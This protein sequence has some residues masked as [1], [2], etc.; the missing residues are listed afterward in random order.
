MEVE[1]KYYVIISEKLLFLSP[2][3]QHTQKMSGND[4]HNL[5]Q[6]LPLLLLLLPER[7]TAQTSKFVE[8]KCHS[9][10][11]L[12]RFLKNTNFSRS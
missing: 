1:N 6:S 12:L 8:Y 2:C 3:H 10:T 9:R 5:E 4:F 11:L 7:E